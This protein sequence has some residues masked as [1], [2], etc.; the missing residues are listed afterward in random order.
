MGRRCRY[1]HAYRTTKISQ[2]LTY[3]AERFPHLIGRVRRH[4]PGGGR[5]RLGRRAFAAG[6]LQARPLGLVF[7]VVQRFLFHQRRGQVQSSYVRLVVVSLVLIHV[8]GR[9]WGGGGYT[10]LQSY[11]GCDNGDMQIS[12]H[13]TYLRT[14]IIYIYVYISSQN[15]GTNNGRDRML[16]K[17]ASVH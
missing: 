7:V 6:R 9:Y 2:V 15:P 4:V 16:Q 3:G 1:L 11:G 10:V 17:R 13:S 14:V 5:R 12:R 8:N